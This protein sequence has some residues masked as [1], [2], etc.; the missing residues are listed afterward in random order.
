LAVVPGKGPDC[1]R[2]NYNLI[3]RYNVDNKER[4][5]LA[6]SGKARNQSQ[7]RRTEPS[8]NGRCLHKA[9]TQVAVAETWPGSSAA[10]ARSRE[11]AGSVARARSA[12]RLRAARRAG[13]DGRVSMPARGAGR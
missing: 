8:L 10:A 11:A 12:P 1:H 4:V 13:A 7:S 9:V 3:G 6:R 2:E 5:C